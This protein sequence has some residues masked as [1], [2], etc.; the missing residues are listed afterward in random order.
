M[1]STD[2]AV[3]AAVRAELARAGVSGRQLARDL[4][5]SPGKVQRRLAGR[6]PF[7]AGELGEIA[8]YLRIPAAT[9]FA[10]SPAAAPQSTAH[11]S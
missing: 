4:G 3:A 1:P 7:R 6:E 8:A 5:L 11:A 10:D 9:F 2:T